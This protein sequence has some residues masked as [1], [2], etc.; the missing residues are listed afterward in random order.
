METKTLTNEEIKALWVDI[1]PKSMMLCRKACLGDSYFFDGKLAGNINESAN[2]I[3]ENDPLNYGFEIDGDTYKEYSNSILIKPDNQYMVYGRSHMR[4]KTIKNVTLEKLRK[5]FL[6]VKKHIVDNKD[7]FINL[8]FDI[9]E[10]IG[11]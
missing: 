8:E 7:N 9:N 4:R 11:G 1:F 2:R 5:R 10:K 3:I 6:E